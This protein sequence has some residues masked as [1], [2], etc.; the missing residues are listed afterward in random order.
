MNTEFFAN[1]RKRFLDQLEGNC[2][3]FFHSG[4]AP[5]KSNDQDM[6]P[7]AVNRNFYYLTGIDEQN[8]WLVLTK[9][10]GGTTETLFIA[11]PDE[12]LIKWNGEMITPQQASERSGIA[13]SSVRFHQDMDRLVAGMVWGG[14]TFDGGVKA[15]FSFDRL[16]LSAAATPSEELA[17]RL[18]EKYPALEICNG[19]PLVY[20]LRTIKTAE[21]IQLI[22]R[23]GDVTIQALQQ[24]MRTAKPGEYE[25]QWQ[26]DYEHYVA[27]NGMRNAF[28]TIAASG[29]N[30]TMLHYHD[31]N[32]I[33]KSGDLLLLDLGAECGY[34]SSD[35]TRTI[36]IGGKFTDRQKELFTIVREAM[37]HAKDK[38]RP[39]VPVRE[40]QQAVLDF[41]K[42]A[43]RAAKLITDDSQIGKYYYHG[44]SHSL[45]LDTHDPSDRAVYEPGMVLTNEPGLYV[46]EEGIGI[47]LENDILVTE[48]APE[49]LIGDR[50]LCISDI[51]NLMA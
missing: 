36:P 17:K 49:D 16:S 2:V 18:K 40:A 28:T 10:S 26:A 44:V 42:K 15:Y 39:G 12:F 46:A 45:G 20:H 21:E 6:H 47:R 5:V 34:Y 9:N 11:Q 29:K 8:V 19:A 43:L 3:A 38:M 22:R 13:V 1:N 33:A 48:G 24:M 32:C 35:V 4:V 31:N 41:Y 51:E 37:E 14:R 50:L 25:Y 30:A 27:R 7:F 23:A